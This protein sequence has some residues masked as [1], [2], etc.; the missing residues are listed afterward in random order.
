MFVEVFDVAVFCFDGGFQGR[1]GEEGIEEGSC[2]LAFA[3]EFVEGCSG[4]AVVEGGAFEHGGA[5]LLEGE[6]A[7]EVAGGGGC[8]DLWVGGWSRCG[9][10]IGIG[11]GCTGIFRGGWLWV[12]GSVCWV[13][14]GGVRWRR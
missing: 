2:G 12:G 6:L 11:V 9:S 8:V 1:D 14:V 13:R 5:V 10:C 7:A 3:K 4:G